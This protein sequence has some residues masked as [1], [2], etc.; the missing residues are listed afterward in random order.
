MHPSW[1]NIGL[2]IYG[3]K[4]KGSERKE[5]KSKRYGFYFASRPFRYDKKSEEL[6]GEE[7]WAPR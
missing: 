5:R 7:D 1:Q 4:R 3:V 6:Y 2:I